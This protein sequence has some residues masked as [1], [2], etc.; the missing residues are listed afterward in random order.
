MDFDSAADELYGLRPEDFT[1][2]RNERA[3]QARSNGD[4]ALAGRIAQLRRPTVSAWLMN[5]LVRRADDEITEL[6]ELGAQLR[7]AQARRRGEELRALTEHRRQ[8]VSRI[9][10]VGRQLA[11]EANRAV[12]ESAM[13]EVEGTLE[14]ALADPD[15]S[16]AVRAGRL[17]TALSYSGLGPAGTLG[18]IAG[19]ATTEGVETPSDDTSQADRDAV[20]H[21]R[22]ALAD[23]QAETR[24]LEHDHERA[25][26][27]ED[28]ARERKD[29]A[30]QH[31]TALE[32]ELDRARAA[33]ESAAD[34]LR[35]ASERAERVRRDLADAR[36]RAE[37]AKTPRAHKV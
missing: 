27:D 2:A 6:L 32:A 20:E 16:A 1:A 17:I 18:R 35:A 4:R 19:P 36:N 23:A 22:R 10:R 24:R 26:G 8:L 29:A 14:A 31:L 37:Q 15:A 12:G 28:E 25:R 5:L 30:D 7:E 11:G 21:Q 34:E 33:A 3:R 9:A 13:Q